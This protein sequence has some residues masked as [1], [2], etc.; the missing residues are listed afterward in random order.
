MGQG[1]RKSGAFGGRP[2]GR[3]AGRSVQGLRTAP[4]NRTKPGK[5]DRMFTSPEIK[6]DAAARGLTREAGNSRPSLGRQSGWPAPV[7]PRP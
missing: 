1:K 6:G 7:F 3:T 4:S 5:P 2:V